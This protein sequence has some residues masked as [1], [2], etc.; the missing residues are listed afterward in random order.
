FRVSA[1]SLAELTSLFDAK[2]QLLLEDRGQRESH[3]KLR[4]ALGIGRFKPDDLENVLAYVGSELRVEA[5]IDRALKLIR[6]FPSPEAA[7]VLIAGNEPEDTAAAAED[8][9][10]VEDEAVMDRRKKPVP[11]RPAAIA[12]TVLVVR[13]L[14]H[15]LAAVP[16]EAPVEELR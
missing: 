16:E 7:R 11:I 4:A 5:W 13:R 3:D 14:Q 6:V 8:E 2:Y 1:E 9:R 12:W 10:P 15:I